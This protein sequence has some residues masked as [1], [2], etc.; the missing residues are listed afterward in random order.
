MHSC[1]WQTSASASIKLFESK[2]TQT[3]ITDKRRIFL[4]RL[5]PLFVP[6]ANP[7]VK[8]RMGENLPDGEIS[9]SP[10]ADANELQAVKTLVEAEEAAALDSTLLRSANSSMADA[11]VHYSFAY[12]DADF[13]DSSDSA[14]SDPESTPSDPLQD[15]ISAEVDAVVSR[16]FPKLRG[17]AKKSIMDPPRILVGNG[18]TVDPQRSIGEFNQPYLVRDQGNRQSG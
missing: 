4:D 15:L 6:T 18:S 17:K 2:G 10:L 7:L 5:R 16:Q 1:V 11:Q 12:S 3:G 9:T 14:E 8:E 13:Y